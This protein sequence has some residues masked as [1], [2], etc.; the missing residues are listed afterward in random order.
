V[1]TFSHA[2]CVLQLLLLL[3]LASNLPQK[4]SSQSLVNS[5]SRD[6]FSDSAGVSSPS[7]SLLF[8]VFRVAS[9]LALRLRPA[10]TDRAPGQDQGDK[11]SSSEKSFQA[12]VAPLRC[13]CPIKGCEGVILATYQIT[14]P[15]VYLCCSR[16]DPKYLR[17]SSDTPQCKWCFHKVGDADPS[18]AA[19]LLRR[20]EE[21]LKNKENV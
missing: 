16:N 18:F 14:K 21:E 19:V 8:V 5:L 1:F 11:I 17:K 9:V 2:F 7:L 15:H 12:A 4:R 20:R 10:Q 13:P 3:R 6:H